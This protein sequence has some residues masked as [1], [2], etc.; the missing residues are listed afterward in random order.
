LGAV[1]EIR[2]S[3]NFAIQPELNFIQKGFQVE[4]TYSDPGVGTVTEKFEVILNYIEIPVMLKGG[5]PFGPARFDVLAGPSIGYALNGKIKF[6]ETANGMTESDSQDID[7]GE[8]DFA[9]TDFSV[10][11]GAAFSLALGESATL[12]ADARYILGLT[13]LN[14]SPDDDI[15]A[16]NRGV[17]LTVGALFPL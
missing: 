12:F 9:R 8:D 10:Q 2:L 4:E 6:T 11:F 1:A 15:T 16:N 7:F 17:A 13:N 3:D 5:V 14:T